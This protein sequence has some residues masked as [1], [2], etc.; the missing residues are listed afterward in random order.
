MPSCCARGPLSQACGE[1][2]LT[3]SPLTQPSRLSL[4]AGHILQEVFSSDFLPLPRQRNCPHWLCVPGVHR[5]CHSLNYK[6]IAFSIY[7]SISFSFSFF[8]FWRWSFALVALTGVQWC[9]LGSLQPLPPRFKK[10]SCLSLPSS[11]DV[12]PRLANF[13]I[14][15]RDRGFAML[16]RLVSNS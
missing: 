2:G 6:H 15:S 14:F 4:L 1:M 10:F 12:S 16:A 8:F 9:D 11:W 7:F 5:A 3:W 13:C